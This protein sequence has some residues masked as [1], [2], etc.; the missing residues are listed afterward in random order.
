MSKLLVTVR[1]VHKVYYAVEVQN[2]EE[3]IIA[4]VEE[5][6]HTLETNN[7]LV[8]LTSELF[9]QSVI[10]SRIIT[11]DEFHMLRKEAGKI[12]D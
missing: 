2:T 10:D 5:L 8:P 7:S 6:T 11:T 12:H 3:G 1:E 9:S 4:G